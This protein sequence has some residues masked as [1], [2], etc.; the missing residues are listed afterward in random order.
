VYKGRTRVLSLVLSETKRTSFPARARY[1]KEEGE[2]ALQESKSWNFANLS[3]EVEGEREGLEL[4]SFR[5]V[6]GFF[7]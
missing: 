4:A 1:R 2:R 3:D 5:F 6:A 7:S